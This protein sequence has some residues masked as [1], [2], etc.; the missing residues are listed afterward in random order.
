MAQA[1]HTHLQDAGLVR[2]AIQ[3]RFIDQL[4]SSRTK[5][6]AKVLR[7]QA[8]RILYSDETP[9]GE[10]VAFALVVLA[11]LIRVWDPQNTASGLGLVNKVR[12]VLELSF[13]S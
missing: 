3:A 7:E 4:P 1:D 9:T 8:A 11:D 12:I 13:Y 2:N 6:E 5:A 10:L